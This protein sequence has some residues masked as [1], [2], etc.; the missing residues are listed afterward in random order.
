MNKDVLDTVKSWFESADNWQKDLFNILWK[1]KDIADAQARALKLILK[2]YEVEECAYTYDVKFPEDIE[3]DTVSKTQ[4]MLKSISDVQGIAALNPTRPLEFVDGLNVVYGANGCG[5]S[6][7]VKVLKKA[8]NPKD[9]T[10]IHSNIFEETH[11]PQKATLTFCDDGEE[12]IINWTPQNQKSC[13]IRIYDT[14]IAQQFVESSTETIYEPKLLHIFTLMAEVYDYI[15]QKI[16]EMI[17]VESSAKPIVPEELKSTNSYQNFSEKK[18]VK[19]IEKIERLFNYS[20]EDKSELCLIKKNFEDSNPSL[21]KN[22]LATQIEILKQLKAN[23]LKCSAQLDESK[24]ADYLKSRSRQ[25]ETRKN[26]EEY[27]L[28]AKSNSRITEFGSDKWKEMWKSATEFADSISNKE[29]NICVL[30][31]QDLSLDAQNRLNAFREIYTSKLEDEQQEAYE[32]FKQKTQTLSSLIQN[33]LNITEI[34]QKLVTNSFEDDIVL[35]VS[36][37]YN[38]LFLRAKW[39]YEYEDSNKNCPTLQAEDTV[40]KLFTETITQ[41]E[42]RCNSL[43]DFIADYDKQLTRKNELSCKEWFSLNKIVFAIQKKILL[44]N[45]IKPK[46]KTNTITK[47][48]NLLSE[49]MITEVYI[50]RFNSE[51]E[52]L[53]P[54]RSIKVELIADGKKGKTSHRVSIKGATEKKRT[55]EI[56]SEGENR[57]VSIAA[58]LADLNSLNKTQAFIFDDPI[59]SLDHNYED[60]VAKQL[61]NLSFKRQVIV[62]THRLAF[63]ETL[64]NYMNEKL[65]CNDFEE[66]KPSFNYIELLSNPLGEPIPNGKYNELKFSSFLNKL[67][68]EDIPKLRKLQ[69]EQDYD[70]YRAKMESICSKMRKNLENGIEKEL[71]SGIVTRYNKNISMQKLRYLNVIKVEDIQLFDKMMTKY[72]YQEHS[73]PSEKPVSIPTI[74]E[75]K[76]DIDELSAWFTD[77]KK[78]REKVDKK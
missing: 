49:K 40:E 10:K 59:T 14:K 39:L 31:Q 55:D 16:S 71:L 28:K 37:L 26:F 11:M 54:T 45:S 1:G 18:S 72:S 22:K 73:Q 43:N 4:T 67:V 53:N 27:L 20:D 50:N 69:S 24:I 42:K 61:V 35:F 70:L 75:L 47:T 65:T 77:F 52:V 74:D 30:C 38:D 17:N 64:S 48:K 62:F 13:P 7:Y 8:E 63:A 66:H 78:R 2:E 12:R 60:A 6:S 32:N 33:H 57:V 5:K 58:F 15:S 23:Y 34:T 46:L 29:S 41:K 76:N 19:E 56:L 9:E 44:L 51:L 36:N 21:T 3:N 25:I 68:N